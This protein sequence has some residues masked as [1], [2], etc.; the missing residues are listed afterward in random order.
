MYYLGGG[1]AELARL[2][3]GDICGQGVGFPATRVLA[4]DVALS[5]TI[6]LTPDEI[7]VSL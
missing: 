3:S 4:E 2:L 1:H 7:F 6:S 5:L